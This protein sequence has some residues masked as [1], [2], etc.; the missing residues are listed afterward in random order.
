MYLQNCESGNKYVGRNE[1]FWEHHNAEALITW[2]FGTKEMRCR[3]S[4]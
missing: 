3:R 1:G 2:G 4:P